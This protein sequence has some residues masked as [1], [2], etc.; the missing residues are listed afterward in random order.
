MGNSFGPIVDEL[1]VQ[2][3]PSPQGF[4]MPKAQL[5]NILNL[6]SSSSQQGNIHSYE[7]PSEYT[8]KMTVVFHVLGNALG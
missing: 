8:L 4:T 3:M 7:V 5:L 2:V 6:K 1:N